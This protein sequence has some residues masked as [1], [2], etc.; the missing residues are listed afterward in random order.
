MYIHT[1][2]RRRG[3]QIDEFPWAA[4]VQYSTNTLLHRITALHEL[5]NQSR[6]VHELGSKDAQA[7]KIGTRSIVHELEAGR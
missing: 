6:A 3:N 2:D 5:Q 4:A 7:I 1:V